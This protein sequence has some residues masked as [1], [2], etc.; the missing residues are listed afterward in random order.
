MR[1]PWAWSRRPF[2]L[3]EAAAGADADSPPCLVHLV[4]KA[5]GL[6]W[7]LGFTKAL[8]QHP[9]GLDYELI[10]LMKGFES[11][12]DASIYFR[13]VADLRPEVIYFPEQGWDLDLY[14]AAAAKLR[15]SRYCFT[16]S[17]TRPLVDG[18]LAK[19][20][21]ALARPNVGIVGATG[22]WASFHSWV[23]YSMGLP[24]AYRS[25][26]PPLEEARTLLLSL[27][28][29]R[30]GVKRRSLSQY[31]E[32]RRTMLRRLPEELLAFDPFP[33][34][35][36]RSNTF[37]L[38]HEMLRELRLFAVKTK[39][40]TY[41]VECGGNNMTRQAQRLGLSTLVVDRTGAAYA[42]GQWPQSRTLWQGNQEGLLVADN[43]TLSYARGDLARRSFQSVFAWGL[44]ADPAPANP[45]LTNLEPANAEQANLE[46]PGP[47]SLSP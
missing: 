44:Q 10:L 6:D 2:T 9:P 33:A 30:L 11:P 32:N 46:P 13:E 5:H 3:S 38:S 41:A 1:G 35:H 28:R 16:N 47:D 25:L 12:A 40:D 37:M 23:T 21:G 29:D 14:F 45:E 39:M 7:F 18:W 27:E 19:L 17:H 22:S 26:M 34:Q 43:Q 20:D 42:P 15:R 8:R 31:L 4:R 36:L 24:S